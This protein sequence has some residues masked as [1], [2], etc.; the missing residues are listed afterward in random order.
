[1]NNDLNTA[2]GFLHRIQPHWDT[3][4]EEIKLRRDAGF[5][6][7]KRQSDKYM[8]TKVLGAMFALDDLYTFLKYYE[9]DESKSD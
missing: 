3:L 8:D 2:I 6:D 5:S 1:M 9:S 4:L 7:L